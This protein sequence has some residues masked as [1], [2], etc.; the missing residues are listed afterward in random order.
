MLEFEQQVPQ[1]D[2]FAV[3]YQPCL[4]LEELTPVHGTEPPNSQEYQKN[5]ICTKP[6]Q[7]QS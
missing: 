3:L 5:S 6:S 4:Y 7:S 2:A 1:A